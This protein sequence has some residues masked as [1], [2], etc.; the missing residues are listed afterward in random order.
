MAEVSGKNDHPPRPEPVSAHPAVSVATQ[1]RFA[2]G[3][4]VSLTG[5]LGRL[6]QGAPSSRRRFDMMPDGSWLL[7]F[8][9]ATPTGQATEDSQAVHLVLN[10]TEK[11]KRLVPAN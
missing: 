8:S 1:P 11:L 7:G 6:D 4:P 10:W 9:T 5:T 2:F 3:N